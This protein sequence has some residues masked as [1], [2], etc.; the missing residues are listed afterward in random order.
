VE[1]T[2][3]PVADDEVRT[4][5]MEL[6]RTALM[7]TDVLGGLLED[8]PDDAFP[9][10]NPGEVL[11]EMV[12][13]TIRPATEAAGPAAVQQATALLGAVCDRIVEDSEGRWSGRVGLDRGLS[14]E[15]RDTGRIAV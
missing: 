11:L 10:E 14:P 7:F 9:G 2:I 13:G 8:L 15:A 12:A 6:L 3:A 4:F 1:S 5:V